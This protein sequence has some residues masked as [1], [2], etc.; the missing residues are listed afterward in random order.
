MSLAGKCFHTT[1]TGVHNTENV[2]PTRR[3][4][5]SWCEAL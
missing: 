1:K 3:A 5:F 2:C 4:G